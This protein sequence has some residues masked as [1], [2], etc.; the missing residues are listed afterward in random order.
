VSSINP[1]DTEEGL[2]LIDSYL[3]QILPSGDAAA[4][5]TVAVYFRITTKLDMQSLRN[6]TQRKP[7]LRIN[8]K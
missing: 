4:V 5:S 7:C 3:I 6:S 1:T 2:S 8:A